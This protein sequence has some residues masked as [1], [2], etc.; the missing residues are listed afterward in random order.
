[1]ETKLQDLK[2][3][4]DINQYTKKVCQPRCEIFKDYTKDDIILY[5]VASLDEIDQKVREVIVKI[6]DSQD[7]ICQMFVSLRQPISDLSVPSV[8][9]NA[10]Q[11]LNYDWVLVLTRDNLVLFDSTDAHNHPMVWKAPIENILSIVWGRILMQSWV[12]WSWVGGHKVEHA[13]INFHTND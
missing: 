11:L 1:M 12:D 4:V 2:K 6:L 10:G 5:T 3:T 13:R 9:G 8:V 7:D